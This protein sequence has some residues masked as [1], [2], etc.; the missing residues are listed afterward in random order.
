MAVSSRLK[1]GG[2]STI[3]TNHAQKGV[4]TKRSHLVNVFWAMVALLGCA[5]VGVRLW[6]VASLFKKD[7][8]IGWLIYRVVIILVEAL[9][10]IATLAYIRLGI[11]YASSTQPRQRCASTPSSDAVLVYELACSFEW[12]F[13]CQNIQ[14]QSHTLLAI[15]AG[16]A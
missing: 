8:R 6:D 10:G 2:P 7:G 9:Y 4:T 15:S 14:R 16:Q 12:C 1:A 11:T 13:T 3:R 5:Y